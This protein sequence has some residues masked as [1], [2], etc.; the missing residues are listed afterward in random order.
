MADGCPLP[1]QP[2]GRRSDDSG[3]ARGRIG[4]RDVGRCRRPGQ[5]GQTLVALDDSEFKLQL[6]A[7]EAALLQ[8]RALIGLKPDDPVSKLDPQNAHRFAKR[9]LRG[10]IP[11]DAENV[12]SD[13]EARTR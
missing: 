8:A 5:A 13:C 2:G 7:A 9:G 11:K 4:A 1:R 10:T 12:G 6:A 3:L